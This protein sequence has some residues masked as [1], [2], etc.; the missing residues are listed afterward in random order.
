MSKITNSVLTKK[1]FIFH[2]GD[3]D[4]Y[5]EREDAI[6]YFNPES[7]LYIFEG[8]ATHEIATLADLGKDFWQI[9]GHVL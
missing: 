8:T 5:F 2:S 6:L 7:R 9:T 4:G 3:E 1:G